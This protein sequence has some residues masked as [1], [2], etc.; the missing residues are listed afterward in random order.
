MGAVEPAF[1]GLTHVGEKVPTVGNLYGPGSTEAGATGVLGRAV[2][3]HDFDVRSLQEPAGQR[4]RGTVREKVDDAVPV[5]VHHDGSVAAALPHRQAST[6]TCVGAGASGIGMALTRR[7]TVARLAGMRRCVR[8]RAPG[9]PPQTMPTRPCVSASRRVR[10][11]DGATRSDAGSKQRCAGGSRGSSSRSVVPR[12][13]ASFAR[14]ISADR[15]GNDGSGYGRI[16][17]SCR[18]RSTDRTLRP[19]GP[20]P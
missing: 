6:P 19:D 7:S 17:S 11:A 16:G 10:R 20:R 9:A 12:C 3:G 15:P 13:S 5:Q 8:S 14:W 18:T 4:R 2:P 1:D